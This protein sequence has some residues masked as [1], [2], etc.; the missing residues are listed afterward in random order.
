MTV[1]EQLHEGV[2]NF[3][4]ALRPLDVEYAQAA[5]AADCLSS[6]LHQLLFVFICCSQPLDLEKVEVVHPLGDLLE[7]PRLQLVPV[8]VFLDGEIP[9]AP[10]WVDGPPKKVKHGVYHIRRCAY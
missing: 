3:S 4:T 10:L 2:A 9:E 1:G 8:I 7:W 6:K 5:A